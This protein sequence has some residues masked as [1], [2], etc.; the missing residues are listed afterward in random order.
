MATL[1][2]ALLLA[3]VS[4]GC[5][6]ADSEG[7]IPATQV[8]NIPGGSTTANNCAAGTYNIGGAPGSQCFWAPSFEQACQSWGG[9]IVPINGAQHCKFNITLSAGF[10]GTT[11]S[12]TVLTPGAPASGYNTGFRVRRGD[13]LTYSGTGTWGRYELDRNCL[14]DSDWFDLCTYSTDTHSCSQYPIDGSGAPL[15][16][17]QAAGLMGSDGVEVFFLGRE[18]PASAPKIINNDGM[19]RIGFNAP[20]SY[21]L[22]AKADVDFTITRCEDAQGRSYQCP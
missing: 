13:R 12:F 16:L 11:A 2:A 4:V 3:L 5:G 17:G 6:R 9:T 20:T 18:L 8:G 7:G 21:N 15:N 10:G 19:L 22:C 14:L 1:S